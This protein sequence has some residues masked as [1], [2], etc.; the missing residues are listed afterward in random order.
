[1]LLYDFDSVTGTV[2]NGITLISNS[3]PYGVEFSSKTKNYYM[4]ENHFDSGGDKIVESV[5][6]FDLKNTNI[7]SSKTVIETSPLYI[8]GLYNWPLTKDISGRISCL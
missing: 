4:T 3:N 1:V 5:T 2:S 7:P 6:Q 8:S